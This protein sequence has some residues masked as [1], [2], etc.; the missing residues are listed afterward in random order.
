[1]D[2]STKPKLFET[3]TYQPLMA[4]FAE[5]TD[6]RAKR[7]VRYKLQS[8]LILLFLSKL[9]GA[10]RPAEIADWVKFR[11]AE[12]KTLLNLDWKKSP[13]EVTWK[14]I[15]E[16]AVEAQ[17]LEKVFGD[18]LL[19]MTEDEKRLWNLDGK[20]VCSVKSEQTD[21]Q[22]HL[23]ALQEPEVNLTVTQKALQAGEN[24]ISAG[25]RLLKKVDLTGK[26]VSGDAIFAQKELSKTVVEN[27]GEYL[28][29]LRANQ[30]KIY[31]TV[32]EHF[33]KSKDK[34]LGKTADLDKGH[35][36]IEERLMLTSFR[37]AGEI[38]FPHFRQVFR[39]KKRSF[40]VKTGKQSE[41]TIY[42]ITSLP[43]E[44][45]GAKE[46]LELTRK[47]WRIENGLHYRRDVTFKEDAVRKKSPNGGQ[48]MAALNNLAIGILRKTGWENIAQARRFYGI[49]FA[50]G[51]KLI[52]NPIIA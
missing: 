37:I 22:L 47:H 41:Q 34:H 5:I 28:W 45:F 50:E 1:M 30:G 46:L 40:E 31:R 35:G 14:R 8:F 29:K 9:G 11:F 42:G 38:E 7:G 15:L 32:K 10:D 26:I 20:V 27:G 24:E 19:L 33:E 18:Y 12:L 36:R 23:L 39:I 25:K 43:V 6:L 21:K 48:I 16:N 4:S 51:I 13:H 44:E 3:K 52:I 2:I 49:K 17:E